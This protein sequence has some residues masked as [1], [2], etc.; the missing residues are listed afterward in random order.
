MSSAFINI[1]IFCLLGP[2]DVA[3]L[4]LR[5]INVPIRSI[6]LL[7]SLVAFRESLRATVFLSRAS[8]V[9]DGGSTYHAVHHRAAAARSG[10]RGRLVPV[11]SCLQQPGWSQWTQPA[12][13]LGPLLRRESHQSPFNFAIFVATMFSFTIAAS[14][15]GNGVVMWIIIRH[16]VMKKSFNIFLFNLALADCLNSVFNAATTW[17]YNLYYRWWFGRVFCTINIFVGVVPT[18]VSVFTMMFVSFDRCVL[19]VP[20]GGKPF[21]GE[22]LFHPQHF[23]YSA[24]DLG[25]SNLVGIPPAYYSQMTKMYFYSNTTQQLD[26]H[27]MCSIKDYEYRN[28]YEQI[29]MLVQ[30]VI[31]LIVLVFTYGRVMWVFRTQNCEFGEERSLKKQKKAVKLI[32]AVVV[33]FMVCWLPYQ[34][35]HA[36]LE[37]LIRNFK[38]AST[39]YLISYWVAM[40]NSAINP[41]IYCYVNK[42]FRIGFRY[43]FRWLPCISYTQRQYEASE[44]FPERKALIDRSLLHKQSALRGYQNG[45]LP[46]PKRSHAAAKTKKNPH[47]DADDATVYIETMK[48][49]RSSYGSPDSEVFPVGTF[50]P[51]DDESSTNLHLLIPQ[52]A[53]SSNL[54]DDDSTT[55]NFLV[56]ISPQN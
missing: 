12:S 11:R 8:L 39:C 24:V 9:L 52:A 34:L 51:V 40:A 23:Y 1:L 31:P 48:Q 33:S 30:Y 25:R 4:P 37:G 35:Y 3:R 38:L 55:H 13:P 47:V 2:L 44:L 41:L 29:I 42:R 26:Y 7:H 46:I 49:E 20:S 15:I 21:K 16:K 45:P 22:D 5:L 50:G 6:L 36:I 14:L 18:C 10:F 28:E 32:L 56:L 53:S 43:A 19:Y 27:W 54:H 17:P